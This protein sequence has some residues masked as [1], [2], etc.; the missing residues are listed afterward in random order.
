MALRWRKDGLLLCAAKSQEEPGD[1]YLDDRLHYLLSVTMGVVV[2][3]ALED[4]N[5]LWHW[6][7]TRGQYIP[8]AEEVYNIDRREDV[9]P[10]PD[11]A[12][13][14]ILRGDGSATGPDGV[15]IP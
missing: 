15:V 5:G 6:V 1:T 2:P 9:A 7:Q 12:N 11:L 14:Y 13:R 4:R 10:P 8:S 3:D